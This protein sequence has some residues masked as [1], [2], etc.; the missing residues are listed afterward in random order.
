MV[1][2]YKLEVYL[3]NSSN[4]QIKLNDIRKVVTLMVTLDD[5]PELK[6]QLSAFDESVAQRLTE[7]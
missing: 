3:E 4:H 6:K 2:A 7:I 1:L 5:V